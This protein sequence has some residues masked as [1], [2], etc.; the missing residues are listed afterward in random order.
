MF[1]FYW[2]IDLDL[3]TITDS[4]GFL[5]DED[6]NAQKESPKSSRKRYGKYDECT[7]Q[8]AGTNAKI[9]KQTCETDDKTMWMPINN[10]AEMDCGEDFMYGRFKVNSLI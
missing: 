2:N 8:A 4:D 9:V 7:N 3:V 6:I 10:E 1:Y 5:S